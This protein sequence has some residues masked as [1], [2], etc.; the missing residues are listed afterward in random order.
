M[1][2]H[3]DGG[4]SASAVAVLG[5]LRE[6]E[7]SA[8]VKSYTP[9]QWRAL[10]VRTDRAAPYTKLWWPVDKWRETAVSGGQRYQ[11]ERRGEEPQW[12]GD[13]EGPGPQNRGQDV[14]TAPQAGAVPATPS[15]ARAP[16]DDGAPSGFVHAYRP[17]P[18]VRGPDRRRA[19]GDGPC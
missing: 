4:S 7:K 16:P 1:A 13:R 19:T 3:D 10:G 8:R 18:G 17:V 2:G 9:E 15:K 14:R 5:L 12:K 6:L 11:E